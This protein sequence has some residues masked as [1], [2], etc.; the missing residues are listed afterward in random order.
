M[1]GPALELL[2]ESKYS[3][4]ADPELLARYRETVSSLSTYE[5]DNWLVYSVSSQVLYSS[6]QGALVTYDNIYECLGRVTDEQKY[7]LSVDYKIKY[8]KPAQ[9]DK[10]TTFRY[11][12]VDL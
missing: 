11:E 9:P 8:L 5:P 7:T 12:Y 6:Y 3:T 2:N 10:L 1:N 4:V